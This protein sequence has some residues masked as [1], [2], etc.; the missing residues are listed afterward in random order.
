MKLTE[1]LFEAAKPFLCKE[2]LESSKEIIATNS[3]PF[4]D[5]GMANTKP[6]EFAPEEIT[7]P[8]NLV[9]TA[10]MSNDND[11]GNDEDADFLTAIFSVSTTPNNCE[12]EIHE[13]ADLIDLGKEDAE[14]HIHHHEHHDHEHEESPIFTNIIE[15]ILRRK[16]SLLLEG[17]NEAELD[18]MAFQYHPELKQQGGKGKAA[19][20]FVSFLRTKRGAIES[21][22]LKLPDG[23]KE[24]WETEIL[25]EFK[26][27]SI[28]NLGSVPYNKFLK[29]V[30]DERVKEFLNSKGIDIE[31]AEG[32][33]FYNGLFSNELVSPDSKTCDAVIEAASNYMSPEEA[34]TLHLEPKHPLTTSSSKNDKTNYEAIRKIQEH[35]AGKE[36][37]KLEIIKWF[38][39]Y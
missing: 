7:D 20:D 5:M 11:F 2:G 8:E 22:E 15:S 14:K 10:K 6:G 32:Q 3:V 13:L 4:S 24:K 39:D 16:D 34:A 17:L 30:I 19:R 12:H 18:E 38:N 33:Q 31:S 27:Y 9:N 36:I 29:K 25:P 35:I 37:E 26:K 23:I 1:Q 28:S 21:G